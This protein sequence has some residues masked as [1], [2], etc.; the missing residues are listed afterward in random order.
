[1]ER[2]E[3]QRSAPRSAQFEELAKEYRRVVVLI[4]RAEV[5]RKRAV[6]EGHA[7][8]ADEI[9]QRIEALELEA[10]RALRVVRVQVRSE[11]RP[12]NGPRWG[13]RRFGR[14]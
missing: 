4:E 11:R 2:R 13:L 9:G 8:R 14:G 7:K 10:E 3:R 6:R 12:T 1:M 5:S